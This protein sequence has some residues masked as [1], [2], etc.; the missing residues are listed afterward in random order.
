MSAEDPGSITRWLE[1]LKA[2]QP[3]A[4]DAIWRRYSERV[5]TVARRLLRSA[6]HRS[7]E[8]GEDV[9]LSAFHGLCTGAAQGRFHDLSDRADLWRL[10]TAITVKTALSRRRWHGRQKRGGPGHPVQR[11]HTSSEDAGKTD[12][13]GADDLDEAVSP[14]PTPEASA[15]LQEQFEKLV[16]ALPDATLRQIAVWRMDG[17][18]NQEIARNLGCVVRTVERKLERIRIIWEEIGLGPGE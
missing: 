13:N 6:P 17:L 10:L 11:I 8:D 2:G 9:A 12:G 18:S 7:V 5:L 14:E 1:G 3:E 15:I 4:A 16:G